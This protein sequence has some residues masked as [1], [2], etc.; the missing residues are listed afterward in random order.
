MQFTR[1]DTEIHPSVP[2]SW[3]T[4][5]GVWAKSALVLGVIA[6]GTSLVSILF[7]DNVSSLSVSMQAREGAEAIGRLAP[8]L[9]VISVLTE[10]I[11]YRGWAYT[12][13]LVWAGASVLVAIGNLHDTIALFSQIRR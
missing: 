12:A 2:W 4:E 7:G 11:R 1:T 8:F 3:W 6:I 10:P 9:A 5:R 13:I